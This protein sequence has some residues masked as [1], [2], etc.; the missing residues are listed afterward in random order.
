M[1]IPSGGTLIGYARCSTDE[2]DLTAQRLAGQDWTSSLTAPPARRIR[3]SPAG[4]PAHAVKRVRATPGR[5]GSR[6]RTQ[7]GLVRVPPVRGG[8]AGRERPRRDLDTNP[9]QST[10][11]ES[12]TDENTTG[13]YPRV[14][15]ARAIPA[16]DLA[17]VLGGLDHAAT[18]LG[19]RADAYCLDCATMPAGRCGQHPDDLAQAVAY[20]ALI[21]V[22]VITRPVSYAAV[23]RSS[24]NCHHA[25][26]PSAAALVTCAGLA[27]VAASALAVQSAWSASRSACT[28][29]NA[30]PEPSMP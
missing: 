9:I 17:T 27:A 10:G 25:R 1:T 15:Q 8:P 11:Q 5:L 13:P 14:L 2:Q 6:G 23:W 4:R 3:S 26:A 28:S 12:C 22:A 7:G 20:R 29:Q 24:R 30:T 19:E 18:L 16:T 21:R